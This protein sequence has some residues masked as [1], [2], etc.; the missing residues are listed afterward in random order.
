MALPIAPPAF[1]ETLDEV[2]A[3]ALI[4][5]IRE[6]NA[7]AV[8][9]DH[10]GADERY[11]DAV[12]SVVPVLGVV[13][14]LAD[15][16]LHA[17][18]WVLNPSPAATGLPYRF[19]RDVTALLG[20]TFALLRP[21]FSTHREAT[22]VGGPISDRSSDAARVL[23]TLGGGNQTTRINA[24]VDALSRSPRSMRIRF[25][26]GA[27]EPGAQ[28]TGFL[29]G[30]E[31]ASTPSGAAPG[32]LPH[33]LA[34]GV[35]MDTAHSL[36]L[37]VRIEAI[38]HQPNI[39]PLLAWADVVVT[40]GG[41]TCW[42]LCAVGVPQVAIALEANQEPNVAGVAAIGAGISL[43]RWNATLTPAMAANAVESLLASAP[44]RSRMSQ[45]GRSRVDGAGA[46]RAAQILLD[47][48]AGNRALGDRSPTGLS[49]NSPQEEKKD[50]SETGPSAQGFSNQPEIR[51]P[52]HT[53][54]QA[55]TN[56]RTATCEVSHA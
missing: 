20:P 14:D 25:I 54:E 21:E 47:R 33:S 42:E 1:D 22:C 39:A 46:D 34:L 56:R 26:G 38:A 5:V 49:S 31:D 7:D 29:A 53:S 17:C 15:R 11:L 16:S 24:I 52:A 51:P 50:R 10:Y 6:T 44:L 41:A 30:A 9:V 32:E 43:G 8:V 3:S 55:A 48:I 19:S 2:D 18:D 37:G 28:A 23:V 4:R 12:R 13:D 40:G 27:S 35:R 45:A 36:A